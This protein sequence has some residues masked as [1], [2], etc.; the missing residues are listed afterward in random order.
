VTIL[1]EQRFEISSKGSSFPY[2]REI[3][4]F[5]TERGRG[6]SLYPTVGAHE[7]AISEDSKMKI[8]K[9]KVAD[10]NL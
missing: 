6:L 7:H 9:F 10:S 8:Q 3:L 5:V 2:F 4:T 1:H